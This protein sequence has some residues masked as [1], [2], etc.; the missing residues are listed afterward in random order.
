MTTLEIC[1]YI[2]KY[3]LI[4]L[5][6]LGKKKLFIGKL[7]SWQIKQLSFFFLLQDSLSYLLINQF[8]EN[9]AYTSVQQ[10]SFDNSLM[11]L[12]P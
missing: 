5:S 10:F 2:T 1:K 8:L 3:S 7:L 9:C 11:L 12:C 4:F 6:S